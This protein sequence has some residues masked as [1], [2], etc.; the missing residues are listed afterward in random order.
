MPLQSTAAWSP[1]NCHSEEDSSDDE[2]EEDT[3]PEIVPIHHN[4]Q[5][6]EVNIDA[7]EEA[8][9]EDSE[10]ANLK[11][12]TEGLPAEHD[13]ILQ[14]ASVSYS[15]PLDDMQADLGIVAKVE[16][17]HESEEDSNQ[18]Q[19]SILSEFDPLTQSQEASISPDGP[20]IG[21]NQSDVQSHDSHGLCIV[22]RQTIIQSRPL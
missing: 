21:D 1:F 14:E 4:K 18:L 15:V 12:S 20:S 16:I 22:S 19:D 13:E 5:L 2:D 3:I 10:E 8:D 17:E 7:L 11:D 9:L 6:E